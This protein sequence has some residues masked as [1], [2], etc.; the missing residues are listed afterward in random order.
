[1]G[2][3]N[4]IIVKTTLKSGRTLECEICHWRKYW[5]LRD[6]ILNIIDSKEERI[7]YTINKGDLK[8]IRDLLINVCEDE[9]G[10]GECNSY[11]LD[12]TSFIESCYK[13]A[14]KIQSA[15]MF[16]DKK[17]EWHE[18]YESYGDDDPVEET[19]YNDAV[20]KIEI[21]FYDSY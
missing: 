8:E 5:G 21:E 11:D 4:G 2:L 12:T 14:G 10:I 7:V 19:D 16:I 17:I 1:M 13:K 20:K 9:N 15:L 18:F 3:D 6:K